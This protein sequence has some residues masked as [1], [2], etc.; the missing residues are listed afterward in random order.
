MNKKELIKQLDSIQKIYTSG[1]TNLKNIY[2]E[3]LD[4]LAQLDDKS[5]GG[6]CKREWELWVSEADDVDGGLEELLNI[7][8]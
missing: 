4:L 8:E 6:Y 7:L 5:L 3:V 2:E 1:K